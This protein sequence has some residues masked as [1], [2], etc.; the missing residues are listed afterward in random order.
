MHIWRQ[1]KDLI[2]TQDS[3]KIGRIREDKTS[4]YSW[5]L[6]TCSPTSDTFITTKKKK[7]LFLS[8]N[9]LRE[10]GAKFYFIHHCL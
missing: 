3:D 7:V 5:Y 4:N 8:R 10:E 1:S 2:R 9:F 6:E